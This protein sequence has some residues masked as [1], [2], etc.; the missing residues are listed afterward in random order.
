MITSQLN[1]NLLGQT[2]R[3]ADTYYHSNTVHWLCRAESLELLV[4][5]RRNTKRAIRLHEVEF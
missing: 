3:I 4:E 2:D 1:G 5:N